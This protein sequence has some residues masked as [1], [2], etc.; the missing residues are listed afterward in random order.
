MSDFHEATDRCI[1][2]RFVRN[3]FVCTVFFLRLKVRL[4]KLGSARGEAES[5]FTFLLVVVDPTSRSEPLDAI[6]KWRV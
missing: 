6:F 2:G 1:D 3:Q 5:G 4:L